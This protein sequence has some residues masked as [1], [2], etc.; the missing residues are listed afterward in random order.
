MTRPARHPPADLAQSSELQSAVLEDLAAA[1]NYIQWYA[2]LARPWLGPDPLEVGSGLGN[3][4]AAWA[5]AGQ[6]VTAS[7][8]DPGRLA[9]L[10]ERFAAEPLVK[11]RELHAPIEERGSYSAVVALNV[12]EHIGDDVGALRS[13]RDLLRPGGHVVLVVP[14][15]PVAMSAFD[16]EIGHHRRYRRSSLRLVLVAAGL[17]PLSVRYYNSAGLLGWLVLMRGL[18]RRPADGFALRAFDRVAVPVL[19]R[20]ESSLPMPFGQSLFAVAQR[21]DPEGPQC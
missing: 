9:L 18:G 11:V 19:R 3:Y 4:A 1:V 12:L 20:V 17:R 7:E 16:R 21:T 13:F 2:D 10:R 14:A 5:A 15:F 8:A 6:P